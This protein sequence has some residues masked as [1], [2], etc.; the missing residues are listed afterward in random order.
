MDGSDFA[1]EAGV[2]FLQAD[3]EAPGAA[4]QL[5]G[6]PTLQASKVV[7]GLLKGGLAPRFNDEVPVEVLEKR[8]GCGLLAEGARRP[9]CVEV[10]EGSGDLVCFQGLGPQ[11][12]CLPWEWQT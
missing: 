5:D 3:G 7:Y 8:V 10:L 4:A 12:V 1:R 11:T 2:S 9:N 6:A